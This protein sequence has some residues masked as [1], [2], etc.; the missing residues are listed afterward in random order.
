M[1]QQPFSISKYT[2]PYVKKISKKVSE[3]T[4]KFLGGVGRATYTGFKQSIPGK[5]ISN[6]NKPA[7]PTITPTAQASQSRPALA[8]ALGLNEKPFSQPNKPVVPSKPVVVPQKPVEPPPMTSLTSAGQQYLKARQDAGKPIDELGIK[9]LYRER[10]F[11]NKYGEWRGSE[12]QYKAMWMEDIQE[13]IKGMNERIATEGI[14]T[15]TG[16]TIVPPIAPTTPTTP[17]PTGTPLTGGEVNSTYKYAP[18]SG[19][20]YTK[21]MD[22]IVEKIGT[23]DLTRLISD[24]SGGE[25]TTPEMELSEE[26]RDAKLAELKSVA[27]QGLSKLQQGLAAKG[28]TFSG[29]R[30]QAE[31]DLAA[32]TLSKESGINREFA[33]RIIDA[34][35]QEQG[36]RE[37]AL[38][39]AETNYNTAL[40][41]MGYV[42][43]PFTDTIEPT[44]EREKMAAPKTINVG[45]NLFQYSPETGELTQLTEGQ[46]KILNAGG[47]LFEYDPE[48]G[49][50]TQIYEAPDK[51]KNYQYFTDDAGHITQYNPNTGE[52]KDLGKLGKT[53]EAGGQEGGYQ[54]TSTQL[55]K[56]SA[57]AGLSMDEFNQ[58]DG[59]T[60]NFLINRG[61]EFTGLKADILDVA[62][63]T[64][65]RTFD[66]KKEA[67][68]AVETLEAPQPVKDM[69]KKYYY[70]LFPDS[71]GNWFVDNWGY[72]IK[73]IR[74]Q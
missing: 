30:T 65:K 63:E 13:D 3:E 69:L 44:L 24:F 7:I 33:G 31:A 47:N 62:N 67:L 27:A 18:M 73:G 40:K 58:L 41:S 60:K 56:G 49:G 70:T 6:L 17:P 57:T 34:A 2:D 53:K 29:I 61:T 35:R 11:E 10:G 59:E 46:P 20:D 42:Y 16:E 71:K 43:N 50:L 55:N 22:N 12:P 64:T 25:I 54:F 52:T 72:L 4:T 1:A 36:R 15:S 38:K 48:T 14:Q 37:T 21:V 32:E 23:T 45:G 39:A 28:M 51:E 19:E 26:D 66:N 9:K 8:S 5:M 68:N 74:G